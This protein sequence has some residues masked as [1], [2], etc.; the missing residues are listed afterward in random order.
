MKRNYDTAIDDEQHNRKKNQSR[1]DHTASLLDFAEGP[2]ADDD[3]IARRM[4]SLIETTRVPVDV[5]N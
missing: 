5:K 2:R 1:E 4:E 3:L